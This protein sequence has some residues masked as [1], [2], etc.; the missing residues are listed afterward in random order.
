MENPI[1]RAGP[2][3]PGNQ[4]LEV[5]VK[6]ASLTAREIQLGEV[7]ALE[8]L[9]LD[10]SGLA[11]S[12]AGRAS[13]GIQELNAS[14]VVTEKQLN[15]FLAGRT[16]DSVRDLQAALLNG[17]VRISGRYGNLLGMSLPF[18]ITAVPEIEGGARLRLDPRQMS[19]VGAPIPGF[20]VQMIGERLNES[21]A[22]ALDVTRLPLPGIRLTGL[23]IETGRLVLTATATI[24]LRAT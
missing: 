16:V 17:R 8:E 7:I 24:E 20:G 2:A 12:S 9:R 6:S 22:K 13:I 23:R 10:A 1:E 21:L 4:P 15:E 14:L 18:T 19:L 5:R 3:S 11:A